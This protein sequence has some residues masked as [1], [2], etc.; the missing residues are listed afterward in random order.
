M[1]GEVFVGIMFVNIIGKGLIGF[2]LKLGIL[3]Y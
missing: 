2:V 1:F 3:I